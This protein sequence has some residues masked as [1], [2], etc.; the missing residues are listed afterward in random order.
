[1]AWRRKVV[2]LKFVSLHNHSVWD[3]RPLFAKLLTHTDDCLDHEQAEFVENTHRGQMLTSL[4][5]A[6]RATCSSPWDLSKVAARG[7]RILIQTGGEYLA[8]PRLILRAT[9]RIRVDRELR[10]LDINVLVNSC[11]GQLGPKK[12]VT[13]PAEGMY[14]PPEGF[15][16]GWALRIP[17]SLRRGTWSQI[18]KKSTLHLWPRRE[19]QYPKSKEV[20]IIG[21]LILEIQRARSVSLLI[22][23]PTSTTFRGKFNLKF[24]KTLRN[25]GS[26]SR[27]DIERRWK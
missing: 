25:Y 15:F 17:Q 24:A 4:S 13:V 1:M 2:G 20:S 23:K 9:T 6:G 27:Q 3:G 14:E 5:A 10:P 18:V 21:E 7:Y 8:P 12:Q 22:Q 26:E 16:V 19:I 11:P